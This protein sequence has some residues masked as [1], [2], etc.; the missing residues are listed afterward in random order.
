MNLKPKKCN[1]IAG[2]IAFV[3]VCILYIVSVNY[4]SGGIVPATNQI[5]QTSAIAIAFVIGVIVYVIASFC[6]GGCCCKKAECKEN[7][8]TAKKKKGAK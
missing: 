1:V 2:I 7:E 8:K 5:S 6:N 3:I 4:V